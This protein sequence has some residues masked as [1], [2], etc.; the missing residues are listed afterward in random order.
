MWTTYCLALSAL[1]SLPCTRCPVLDLHSL[2]ILRILVCP[3]KLFES[4]TPGSSHPFISTVQRPLLFD[5]SCSKFDSLPF[6]F[7]PFE[8]SPFNFS[9]FDF[10][11]CSA[12][13]ITVQ[14][15]FL[16][17]RICEHNQTNSRAN[18]PMQLGRIQNARYKLFCWESL[19][20]GRESN[21]ERP[22]NSSGER[23]RESISAH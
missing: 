8:F 10:S 3:L 19:K 9:R 4:S 17:I 22:N 7:W 1:Y 2:Q 23:E 21:R 15:K 16:N 13:P 5:F 12:S 20:S 14:I 18:R 6:D 11:L